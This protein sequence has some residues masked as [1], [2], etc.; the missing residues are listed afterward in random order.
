MKVPSEDVRKAARCWI[1]VGFLL[2]VVTA[3]VAVGHYI[4]DWPVHD[5]ATGRFATPN[6]SLGLFLFM[7]GS[8]SLLALTGLVIRGME[9]KRHTVLVSMGAFFALQSMLALVLVPLFAD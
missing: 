8:G 4:Y 3:V 7:G 1:G 5:E 9:P 2:V 6:T